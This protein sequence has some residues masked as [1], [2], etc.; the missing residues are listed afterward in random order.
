[1]WA[2][3]EEERERLASDL[4]RRVAID[5][6]R[7]AVPTDDAAVHVLT[8]DRVAGGLDYGRQQVPALLHSAALLPEAPFLQRPPDRHR[9]AGWTVFQNVIR[10]A[11]LDALHSDFFSD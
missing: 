9:Q 2:A 4:L 5:A 1:M 10:C 11:A 3:P 8:D 6:L 7:P